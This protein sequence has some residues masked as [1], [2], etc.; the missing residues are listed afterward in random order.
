MKSVIVGGTAGLGREIA[1]ILAEQGHS[2]LI[3]GKDKKDVDS[4]VAD[5]Q[6]RYGKD[7]Y[8]I[9]VDASNHYIFSETLTAASLIFGNINYLF[10]PIGASDQQDN[11]DIEIT[12]FNEI[13]SSNFFSV[14][15]AVKVFR[16][17]FNIEEES[18]I[19]G[20]SS[21][22]AIRG[23]DNNVIYAASKRALE[24]YFESLRM[25]F[26]DTRTLVKFYRI[27]YLDTNQAYGK[28]LLFPKAN[29]EKA[30][31]KIVSRLNKPRLVTYLPR[32]WK[33]I[34]ILV[35]IAPIGLYKKITA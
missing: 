15:L 7:V 25:I 20:F 31:R 16:S 21:I 18:A 23:R 8:G 1:T 22:S 27:G 28:R 12:K 9:A 13:M 34:S 24:S 2:I 4:S 5:L 6:I 11:A 14:V 10:L 19:I 26:S 33:V 29:P 17:K 3:I 30:A 32:Y 35:K